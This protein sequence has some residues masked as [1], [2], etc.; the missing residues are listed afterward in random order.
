MTL[1]KR[2][3]YVDISLLSPVPAKLQKIEA[4]KQ[5]EKDSDSTD[6]ESESTDTEPEPEPLI[7]EKKLNPYELWKLQSNEKHITMYPSCE[8]TPAKKDVVQ[9]VLSNLK[10]YGVRVQTLEEKLNA[11]DLKQVMQCVPIGEIR[12]FAEV[13]VVCS[14][15]IIEYIYK[16]LSPRKEIYLADKFKRWIE[17]NLEMQCVTERALLNYKDAMDETQRTQ[18]ILSVKNPT[19]ESMV[20]A[21]LMPRMTTTVI[22]MLNRDL[23]I[24]ELDFLCDFARKI[25]FVKRLLNNRIIEC[26]HDG[27][28][29]CGRC[30]P[31]EVPIYRCVQCMPLGWIRI[32]SDYVLYVK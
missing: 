22:E 27:F 24:T 23:S 6:T 8:A 16:L 13:D 28:F 1:V 31:L 30:R 5:Q 12:V 21:C 9:A 2:T 29:K 4:I 15:S 26:V 10:A 20:S 32:V 17:K 18:W 25:Q 7:V 14:N 11:F 19:L 3:P